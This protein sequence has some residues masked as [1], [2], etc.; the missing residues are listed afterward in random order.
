MADEEGFFVVVGVDK[1]AGD[2]VGAIGADFACVGVEYVY[3][4]YLDLVATIFGVENIDIRF[5]EDNE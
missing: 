3:A 1:P 5:A 4:V 2:A